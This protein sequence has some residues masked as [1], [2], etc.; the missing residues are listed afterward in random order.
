MLLDFLR[1]CVCSLP[2]ETEDY[3]SV[4]KLFERES[5]YF[6]AFMPSILMD[7]SPVY[8]LECTSAGR[9]APPGHPHVYIMPVGAHG[10][11]SRTL[12]SELIQKF[13]FQDSLEEPEGFHLE[14]MILLCHPAPKDRFC[15]TRGLWCNV[16]YCHLTSVRDT[17]VYLL[18]LPDRPEDVWTEIVEAEQIPCD[19]VIDSHKGMGDWFESTPLFR[20]MSG[21]SAAGLLP[22]YYYRGVY[23][24]YGAPQGFTEEYRIPEE[25]RVHGMPL[26]DAYKTIYRTTWRQDQR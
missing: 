14:E 18:I 23:I 10:D 6:V 22:R 8:G 21:T 9:Y 2:E 25:I 13:Y 16:L 11:N 17:P 1:E 7:L 20:C 5:E 12:F 26:D 15:I 4:L 24:S 3:R 19:I